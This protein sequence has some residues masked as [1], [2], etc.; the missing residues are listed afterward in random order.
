MWTEG[1]AVPAAAQRTGRHS[2]C[3]IKHDSEYTAK[4]RSAVVNA[5]DYSTAGRTTADI[6]TPGDTAANDGIRVG[7]QEEQQRSFATAEVGVPQSAAP[8]APY[9]TRSMALRPV[10][11]GCRELPLLQP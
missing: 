6:I 5:A 10:C 9:N 7:K 1:P 8:A 4:D 11:P 3:R 2:A